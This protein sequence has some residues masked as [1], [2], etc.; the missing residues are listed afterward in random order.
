NVWAIVE[1]T[2]AMIED[3]YLLGRAVPWASKRG[4]L[5]LIPHAGLD[6][7]AYYDRAG[8]AL[9][10]YYF[11]APDGRR[12][13]TCLSHDIVAHELGHAVLDGLKPFY[14]EVSSAQTA[15]FHEYFGDAVAMMSSLVTRETARVVTRGGP[16]KLDPYNVVS[17]IASEFGAAIRKMPDRKEYLRGAWNK[18]TAKE[19]H[20][21]FEEHDWSEVLTGIYYDLLSHLYPVMRRQVESENGDGGGRNK[22]EYYAMRA[23]NR[24]ATFTAGVM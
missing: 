14:N 9:Q 6:R 1:R 16:E 17:A 23:L 3:E 11:D 22:R 12:I 21:K 24:A 18:R 13:H 2:L 15:G 19:L 8:G 7:N 10:F 20:G 5:I 4:R